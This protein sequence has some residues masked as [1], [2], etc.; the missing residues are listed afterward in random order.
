M[1]MI[2]TIAQSTRSKHFGMFVLWGVALP[3]PGG[4]HIFEKRTQNKNLDELVL[5]K[6]VHRP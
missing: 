6:L 1:K 3:I 5:L 2:K 4:E